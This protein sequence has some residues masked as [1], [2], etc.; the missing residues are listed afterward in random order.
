VNTPGKRTRR[1]REF[2]LPPVRGSSILPGVL[3]PRRAGCRGF[4]RPALPL[5]GRNRSCWP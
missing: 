3:H 2:L 5:P 1:H 4:T